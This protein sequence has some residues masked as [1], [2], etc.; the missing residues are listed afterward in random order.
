MQ[1]H[2]WCVAAQ[3][4]CCAPGYTSAGR[5]SRGK[6]RYW[7]V[8]AASSMAVHTAHLCRPA[9][10][11]GQPHGCRAA[12]PTAQPKPAVHCSR[13]RQRSLA[14]KAAAFMPSTLT[15]C[16][17]QARRMHRAA[18]AGKLDLPACCRIVAAGCTAAFCRQHGRASAQPIS[19]QR[20]CMA[21]AKEAWQAWCTWQHKPYMRPIT[22]SQPSP[23]L[24]SSSRSTRPPDPTAALSMLASTVASGALVEKRVWRVT[25]SSRA[26]QGHG[27][28]GEVM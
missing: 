15:C 20:C 18:A 12:P 24:P 27:G 19:A 16:Y 7:I 28:Q 13:T 9:L 1:L 11:A 26:W 17:K 22:K 4:A 10:S 23:H 14:A 5:R 8:K 3:Q 25:T 21:A 2:R 6:S